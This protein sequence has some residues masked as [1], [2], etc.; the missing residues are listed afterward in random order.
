MNYH[1]PPNCIGCTECS[2]LEC[3]D[4]FNKALLLLDSLKVKPLE[5][6]VCEDEPLDDWLLKIWEDRG[7]NVNGRGAIH[8]SF[9]VKGKMYI[10]PL[11]MRRRD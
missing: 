4:S 11:D 10:Y 6:E 8:V 1:R 9:V 7:Y 2:P 5:M 3:P